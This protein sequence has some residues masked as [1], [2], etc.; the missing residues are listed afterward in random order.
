MPAGHF[1]DENMHHCQLTRD[2]FNSEL[3]Q[4]GYISLAKVFAVTLEP[5]GKIA[6]VTQS[7]VAT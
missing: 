3:R 5:A 6:V 4:L 1:I 7:E 2:K